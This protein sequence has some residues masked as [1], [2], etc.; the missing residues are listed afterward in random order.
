MQ[1]SK[2][3][4][5]YFAFTSTCE[6]RVIRAL[7]GM[8]RTGVVSRAGRPDPIRLLAVVPLLLVVAP[9]HGFELPLSRELVGEAALLGTTATAFVWTE[10]C[11]SSAEPGRV[12]PPGQPRPLHPGLDDAALYALLSA[13][14]LPPAGVAANGNSTETVNAGLR[15]ASAVFAAAALKDVLKTLLPRPRPYVVSEYPPHGASH[16]SGVDPDDFR[17]FP[18]G[19][20]TLAWT[21]FAQSI[22][23]RCEYPESAAAR[24]SLWASGALAVTVSALRVASGAHYPG[25]VIIGAVLGLLVGGV[26]PLISLPG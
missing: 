15:Y 11:S 22:R 20:A 17:S 14:A 26:T 24:A 21:A 8:D 12:L 7:E 19:H 25:D 3:R 4:S 6:S 5:Q 10:Y 16:G 18:S 2:R 1:P 13:M 23:T 9:L